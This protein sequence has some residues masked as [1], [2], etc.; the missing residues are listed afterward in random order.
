VK[1]TMPIKL[2]PIEGDICRGR[3]LGRKRNGRHRWSL[4]PLCGKGRWEEIQR[5]PDM[6][7]H[8]C[9]SRTNAVKGTKGKRW[10][11]QKPHPRKGLS[12]IEEYGSEKAAQI[13]QKL[14]QA[15][16]GEN[17]PWYGKKAEL[18]P[19]WKGGKSKQKT[20]YIKVYSPNHPRADGKGYVF[21]HILVWMESYPLPEGWDV[22]HI[23][24]IKDD[25]RLE[26]LKSMPHAKHTFERNQAIKNR[27]A[28]L[29]QRIT[30]LEA[31]N[32]ALKEMLEEDG[33]RQFEAQQEQYERKERG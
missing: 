13:K 21:E 10:K 26:N 16:S 19:N 33:L 7:C 23:N 31:E 12:Y 15:L 8:S 22:H 3:E 11:W 17:H 4:C 2:M 20:G 30:I 14:S 32:V 24:G 5:P 1:K 29:E 25:N 27:L 28:T 18:C 9:A 6:L